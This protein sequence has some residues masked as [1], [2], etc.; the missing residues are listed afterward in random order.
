MRESGRLEDPSAGTAEKTEE[1]GQ[2]GASSPVRSETRGTGRPELQRRAKSERA[3]KRKLGTGTKKPNG[4]MHDPMNCKGIRK[5]PGT[6]VSGV[7]DF[8]RKKQSGLHPAAN[9]PTRHA[10]PP[11]R[12]FQIRRR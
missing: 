3:G 4:T 7:F 6:S 8:G 5:T 2:L 1:P 12:P 10:A 11:C 9:S